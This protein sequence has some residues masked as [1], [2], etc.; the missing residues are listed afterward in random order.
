MAEGPAARRPAMTGVPS[1]TAD[2]VELL[3]QRLTEFADRVQEEA[4]RLDEA[5][6]NPGIAAEDRR[7]ALGRFGTVIRNS[8]RFM[9]RAERVRGQ[10]GTQHRAVEQAYWRLHAVMRDGIAAGSAWR[11]HL[12]A[13]H[14]MLSMHQAI[15]ARVT[16]P[17]RAR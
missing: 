8:Q 17:A 9:T 3:A 2:Q 6:R 16:A 13:T 1:C 11:K 14:E 4:Y 10:I 5:M 12:A 15:G 7:R